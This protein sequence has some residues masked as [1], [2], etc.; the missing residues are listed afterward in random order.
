MRIFI[1]GLSLLLLLADAHSRSFAADADNGET[2]SK[3]WC[4]GCHVVSDEQRKGTDIA[5]SFTS[6]ASRADFDEDK[7]AT[8]L[9]EPHPKMSNMELSRIETKNI[10]AY[11]AAQRRP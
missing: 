4:T 3:R 9:L 7:L 2:L 10:A 5:P 6:I 1:F 8:F 11:I